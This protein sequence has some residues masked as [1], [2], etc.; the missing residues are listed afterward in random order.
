[1]YPV[2][3][4]MDSLIMFLHREQAY[5]IVMTFPIMTYVSVHFQIGASAVV[6]ASQNGHHEVVRLQVEE[7]SADVN[8][9]SKV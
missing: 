9:Q 2:I 6:I 8:I 5:I 1:M 4:V 7:G 3:H